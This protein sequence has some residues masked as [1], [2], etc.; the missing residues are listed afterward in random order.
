MFIMLKKIATKN[1]INVFNVLYDK[2]ALTILHINMSDCINTALAEMGLAARI[3]CA[4]VFAKQ[5]L[6]VL[7]W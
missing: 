7:R 4:A 1:Y 6:T 2:I 5:V 3:F